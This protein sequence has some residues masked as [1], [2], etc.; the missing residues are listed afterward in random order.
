VI[1]DE[2]LETSLLKFDTRGY[3]DIAIAIAKSALIY[4]RDRKH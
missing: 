1:R 2:R 4:A 3:T